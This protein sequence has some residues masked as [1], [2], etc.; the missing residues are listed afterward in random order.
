MHRSA[1]NRRRPNELQK[2]GNE[3][4]RRLFRHEAANARQADQPA[5][6]HGVCQPVGELWPDPRV[7]IPPD[8]QRGLGQGSEIGVFQGKCAELCGAYHSQMLFQVKVVS[9]ADYDA[10][11]SGLRAQGNVGM[12]DNS[13]SREKIEQG[14]QQYLP[15]E[16][17]N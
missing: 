14:A 13:L 7:L 16:A 10:H 9:Q 17:G 12:L 11:M 15:K 8:D 1:Q 6:R 4:L 5:T 3:R 2:Q